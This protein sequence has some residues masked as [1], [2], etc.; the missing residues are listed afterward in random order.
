MSVIVCYGDS[1]TH[2]TMPMTEAGV[3]VRLPPGDRWP[4][5]M[6]A[7][8]GHMHEVISEGLP[9]RTTVHDDH[10][11]G[12]ARN[13]IAVL[14][15]ILHSHKPIDLLILM[16]GTN[17]LKN[18]F[19]VTAYEIGRALERMVLATRAE[20]VV[21][22][23]LIVCPAPVRELGCLSD[24]FAGAEARQT[25]LPGFVQAVA[26]RQGCGFVAAGAHAHVSD[27]DGV[28]WEADQHRLFGQVMADIVRARL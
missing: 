1:N 22:D 11:E 17:D 3:S 19:A 7:G 23:I 10:V 15:A 18:R 8:L 5:V 27:Q 26:E 16:L 12:G 14:P 28:H 13:G 4:D 25:G 9:G 20:D 21:S 2:G 24:V 6:A